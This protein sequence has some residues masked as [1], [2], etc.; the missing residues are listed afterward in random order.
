ME[1][2]FLV[3]QDKA[4]MLPQEVMLMAE[5]QVEVEVV[6]MEDLADLV[7]P[8]EVRLQAEED[9]VVAQEVLV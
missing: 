3:P 6:I 7:L 4:Q 8:E 1:P 9:M 2:I 5:A